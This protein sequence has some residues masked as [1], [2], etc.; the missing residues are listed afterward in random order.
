VAK[1]TISRLFETSK[2]LTTKS[3][4][5]L[6][7]FISY[8]ADFAEQTLRNLKN[9][10]T[11]ADNVNCQISTYG[12][13]H[14]VDQSINTAGKTP[15]GIIPLRVISSTTGIDTFG[16]YVADNGAIRIK[17]GFT[18]APAGNIDLTVVILFG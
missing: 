2:I 17:A 5:E 8:V 4:Q 6:Q 15:L 14:N 12:L 10:L 1:I 9:G 11:F 7:E 3:G 13:Q 18:G 16:W